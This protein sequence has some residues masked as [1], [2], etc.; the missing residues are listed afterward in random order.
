MKIVLFNLHKG[1]AENISLKN[2]CSSDKQDMSIHNIGV[3]FS[4]SFQRI[5][6]FGK[7]SSLNH[8]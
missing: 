8:N 3:K 1:S 6:S 7:S 4:I 2:V 5:A